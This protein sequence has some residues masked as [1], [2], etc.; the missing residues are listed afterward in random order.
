MPVDITKEAVRLGEQA[1]EA[2]KELE[3]MAEM[4]RHTLS[5][6]NALIGYF[7][8][9]RAAKAAQVA[10]RNVLKAWRKALE[11]RAEERRG[12]G[13]MAFRLPSDWQGPAP[14]PD[15]DHDGDPNE[16]K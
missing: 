9:E 1:T 16:D 4:A 15:H 8:I 2:M 10:A 13:Q 7:A 12:D 11:D 14:E 5:S 3:V 6:D